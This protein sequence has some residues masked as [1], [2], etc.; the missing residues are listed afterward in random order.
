MNAHLKEYREF[1]DALVKKRVCVLA[2]WAKESGWPRS[3]ENERFNQ[4]LSEL[5][6]EQREVLAEMLQQARDGGIHDTLAYLND[7]INLDGLRIS[8]NGIELA[9]EPYR[10]EIYFDW[11]ARVGGDDW[12]EH[13][14]EDKYKGDTRITSR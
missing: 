7:E 10:T 5:T 2:Q 14:L 4:F 6:L 11:M 13:Q 1:V 9:V 8:R 3:P 12:P